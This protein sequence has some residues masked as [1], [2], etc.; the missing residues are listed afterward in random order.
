[1]SLTD[2]IKAEARRLGFERV[3]IVP[4]GP[5]LTH[6][7]YRSWLAEGY[8][9]EMAYLHRHAVPKAHAIGLLS[10]AR[11]VICLALNYRPPHPAENAA[12]E[13]ALRV[14]VSRYAWGGDYHDLLHDRL[15]RLAAFIETRSGGTVH[16]RGAVDSAP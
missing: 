1:M 11:S 3:G 8:A 10:S 2:Q 9:G 6:G 12:A 4:A 15:E 16:R 13:A 7:Y 14:R 5:A